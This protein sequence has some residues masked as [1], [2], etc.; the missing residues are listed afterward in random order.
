MQHPADIVFE[1]ASERLNILGWKEGAKIR[2][3]RWVAPEKDDPGGGFK[4]AR[5]LIAGHH[6]RDRSRGAR[7]PLEQLA[8]GMRVRS[9]HFI[10]TQTERRRVP[11]EQSCNASGM[12]TGLCQGL[13]I[14]ETSEGLRCVELQRLKPTRSRGRE[15]ERGLPNPG[16]AMEEENV[17][18]R[19]ALEIRS[20]T[21]LDLDM[22]KHRLQAFRAAGFTPHTQSSS[23]ERKCLLRPRQWR[24]RATS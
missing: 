23:H 11:S 17:G 24:F 6:Q 22:S 18:V 1:G 13:N 3:L 16:R 8:L 19:R 4:D 7:H 12:L 9:I 2:R 14:R 20:E 15:H 21:L 10:E 5:D